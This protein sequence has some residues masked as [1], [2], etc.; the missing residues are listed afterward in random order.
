MVRVDGSTKL[1]MGHIARCVRLI[2]YLTRIVQPSPE[3]SFAV[4]LD[5]KAIRFIRDLGYRVDTVPGIR[6]Q[7]KFDVE[8]FPDI[9]EETQPDLIILDCNWSKKPG[10]LQ[11]LPPGL[12]VISLHEH[13]FPVLTDVT[14]AI[15]PSMVDQRPAPGGIIGETHFQGPDYVILYEGLAGFPPNPI[16]LHDPA[17]VVICIGGSD[18]DGLTL[19]VA[20]AL[21]EIEGLKIEAVAGP[22]FREDIAF[23]LEEIGEIELHHNPP[24][25]LEILANADMAITSG[26]TTMFEGMALGVPTIAMP[27][28]HYETEQV[29]ICSLY[30]AVL[31]IEMNSPDEIISLFAMRILNDPD[32]RERLSMNGRDLID[33]K[34]IQRVGEIIASHLPDQDYLN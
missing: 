12:P 31:E 33:G 13:N 10:Q 18:P 23:K 34:G 24:G 22:L 8:V 4:A 16:M 21:L 25:I 14:V 5:T 11:K 27:R 1:G 2:K 29:G 20:K 6:G 15:N 9:I 30:G 7:E 26:A 28:N 3:V 17:R 32:L 19:V